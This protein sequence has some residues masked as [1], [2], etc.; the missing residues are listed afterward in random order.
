MIELKLRGYV[1]PE[2]FGGDVQ[3]AIDMAEQ[4]DIRKVVLNGDYTCGTLILPGYTH[5]VLN[6]TLKADLQSKKGCGWCDEQDR[7]FLEGGKLDGSLY[8]YNTRRAVVQN[9]VITGDVTYEFS[10][11]MRMEHCTV[12][13]ALKIGRGCANGILQ[14]LTVGSALISN[15]VFCGDIV[16]AKDPAIQNILL[17]DSKL[18]DGSVCLVASEDCGMMNVQVDHITAPQTAV[19]VGET[20]VSLPKE[21]YFNLTFTDLAAPQQFLQQN[22]V[23]HMYLE[24]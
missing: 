22:D 3:T 20:E 4:L 9:M 10:R 5:L 19:I 11:D 17:R 14:Y 12:G 21:R 1:T 18:T 16:L 2:D 7:Y 24:L 15:Q 23:K 13:G 6:G 8:L